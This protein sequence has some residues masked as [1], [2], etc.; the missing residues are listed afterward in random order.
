MAHAARPVFRGAAAAAMAV[1][2]ASGCG[3]DAPPK[4]EAL[5][6]G[7]TAQTLPIA[8][9]DYFHAM[10]GGIALTPDEVKGRDTWLVWSGGNDRFW[11]LLSRLTGG[12]FD[13][14][15]ILSS[16]PG[17]KFGRA[18]RF[19]TFGVMNEPCFAPPTGPD[20]TRYGLWLDRRKPVCPPDPFADAKR[21]PGIRTGARGTTVPVGSL[22]GDPSGVVGLR[23]F[24]NPD[25]DA[26]AAAKW[27]PKRYYT[28]PA[29][30]RSPDL[31]R[32]YRVGISC[33]FCHVGPNPVDPPADPE[34][35]GWQNLS[36][37]IGAQYLRIDRLF[38]FEADASSFMFQLLH[39]ER[40]G[41]IDT[42][43]VA[44]DSINNPRN[45][46]AIYQLGARMRNA[47]RRMPELLAAGGSGDNKQLNQYVAG[48]P[49][50]QFYKAPNI[51][52]PPHVLK[53]GADSVGALGALN[54][55]YVSIGVDSEEWLRHF[56]PLAGGKPVSPVLISVMRA[57]STYYNATEARTPDVALFFLKASA[58][59]RLADAPGGAAY[60]SA[61]PAALAR[62]KTVFADNCARCHS[63]K[64]PRPPANADIALCDAP[65]YLQCFKAYWAWTKTDAFKTDMRAIVS[66]PDFLDG[67]FL[68]N[69]MR[70]PITMLQT[71]A[72]SPLARNALQGHVWDNFSSQSY[73][74]LPAVGTIEIRDPYTGARQAY[75]M[76]GGGRGYTRVPSLVSIWASAPFL[77][78]NSVGVFDGDPSVAG[79]MRAFDDA[80]H[81]MLWP[82]TREKDS[83][84]GAQGVGVIDRTTAAST[85]RV[86][87]A[88]VPPALRPLLSLFGR[89]TAS[90]EAVE[91]GPVPK[92]T[93][94]DL[95]ANLGLLPPTGE[96]FWARGSH[97]VQLLTV[98]RTLHDDLKA[99]P[100]RP[101]DAEAR[102][103]YAN[104]DAPLM[105]LSNCPDFEV[106]KGHYFG[107]RLSDADKTDLIAFLKTF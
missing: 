7:R 35:P 20:P 82:G 10:D 67:N 9:E 38:S 58:P 73:K 34:H 11:D 103:V 1:L 36:S 105:A 21:Y 27:D 60:L 88:F 107:A 81:K 30:Y 89:E 64:A 17:A 69:D 61:D 55:V 92:G 32:P 93:P 3:R 62:G 79:R 96:G 16:Y 101:T 15:K 2:F 5:Q 48:G 40:P 83:V 104:L 63:S 52:W 33:G 68:S 31:V 28:D 54:R 86:P 8:G 39:T 74:D 50:A 77:L 42:S 106:N 102:K 75:A 47:R 25:F 80:I 56:N 90:G 13:L 41:T 12:E 70:I 71:N 24:P 59:H 44:T 84:L 85:V 66:A 78:N 98:L 100:P 97:D 53:D 37:N 65:H 23:L 4:D 99:L 26:A 29:Y 49:L 94:V 18:N 87:T 95:I 22:Y 91:I 72:C 45:M 51:V 6:S 19:A 76:P 46:N 14:I 43:L 57:Q